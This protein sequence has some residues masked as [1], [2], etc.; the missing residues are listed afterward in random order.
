M[1][2]PAFPDRQQITVDVSIQNPGWKD[3]TAD[4]AGLCIQAIQETLS[5]AD[6]PVCVRTATCVD[7]SVVLADDD[8]IRTLNRTYRGKDA[9]TNVLSFP[10]LCAETDAPIPPDAQ[11]LCLG[12]LV[13]ALETLQRECI[14][15]DKPFEAHFVHLVVH[16]TLHLLGYDHEENAQCAINMKKKEVA[17]LSG[18]GYRNP[19]A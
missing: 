18:L 7:V 6:L 4:P 5:H 16:G 1:P 3:L 15:F 11:E 8:S 17:I 19:Y 9:P 2:G 10:L 14:E 12:D 13:L